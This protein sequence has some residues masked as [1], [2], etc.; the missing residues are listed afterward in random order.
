MPKKKILLDIDEVVIFSGFLPLIN[1][2]LH[3]NYQIDDFDTYYIDEVAIPKERFAEF[4][5]FQRTRSLYD[6]PVVLPG[7]IETLKKL[8]EYYDIYPCTDCIDPFDINASGKH[9]ADKFA[10]LLQ[11]L[12][13]IPPK[14]FIFTGTKNLFKADI[15]IDDRIQNLDPTIETKILFPSYHNKN[16]T[17]EILA[18]IGALRAGYD[19]HTGWQTIDDLLLKQLSET[20]NKLTYKDNQ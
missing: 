15:Q 20:P 5:T 8:S 19:W 13:F 9:F 18:E 10:L 7:A 2:F 12:P 3:T 14:N 11:L 1:E 6:N 16:I 4:K 17:D